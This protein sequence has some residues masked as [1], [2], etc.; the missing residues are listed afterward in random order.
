MGDAGR[1]H[2]TDERVHYMT[3]RPKQDSPL[4]PSDSNDDPDSILS[5]VASRVDEV[6]G[7]FDRTDRVEVLS[8]VILAMATIL[9]T[10]GAYQSSLWGSERARAVS[11]S[12]AL[13]TEAA[14]AVSIISAQSNANAQFTIAWLLE[15][16]EG[17]EGGMAL[18]EERVGD[19]LRPAFDAWLAQVPEGQIPPDTPMDM[20]EFDLERAEAQRLADRLN[21]LADAEFARA[22]QASKSSDNFVLVAVIM[23][24]V[25]FFAGVGTKFA[26]RWVRIAMVGIALVVFLGGLA[27]AATLPQIIGPIA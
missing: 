20:P 9:A 16:E 24:S 14:Q 4:P 17:D 25:L 18:L 11:E 8:V 26:V 21:E 2:R 3:A 5:R 27:Y 7:R 1:A 19:R 13:R 10:W 6:A 12:I 23:A 22:E 15:A